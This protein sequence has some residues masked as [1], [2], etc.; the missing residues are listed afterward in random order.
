MQTN[1]LSKC[2]DSVYFR[3]DRSNTAS[4][5]ETVKIWLDDVECTG[6][7][8]LIH[9]CKHKG[10]GQGNCDHNEDVFLTC[11]TRESTTPSRGTLNYPCSNR[12]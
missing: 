1:Y 6:D 3:T 2:V 11:S 10:W 4:M 5:D 9:E 12:R 7:E 8:N